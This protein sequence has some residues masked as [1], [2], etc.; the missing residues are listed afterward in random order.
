MPANGKIILTLTVT[1]TAA[2]GYL[3]DMIFDI[4]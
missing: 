3:T 2:Y 1:P 4:L